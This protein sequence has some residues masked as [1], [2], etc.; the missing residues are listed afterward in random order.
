MKKI[1]MINAIIDK[2]SSYDLKDL[3]KKKVD[4]INDIYN[5]LFPKED[6]TDIDYNELRQYNMVKGVGDENDPSSKT[7]IRRMIIDKTFDRLFDK[8][9]SYF[10]EIENYEIDDEVEQ[11]FPRDSNWFNFNPSNICLYG[12]TQKPKFETTKEEVKRVGL[13]VKYDYMSS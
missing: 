6:L 13:L 5:E 8:W 1:D 10:F 9:N 11:A 12:L 2:N 4:E 3:K 7:N